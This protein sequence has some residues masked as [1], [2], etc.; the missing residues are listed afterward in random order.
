MRSMTLW[1][2]SAKRAEGLHRGSPKFHAPPEPVE[3]TAG[4]AGGRSAA[5][6]APRKLLPLRTLAKRYSTTEGWLHAEVAAGNL[7]A[8]CLEGEPRVAEADVGRWL[9]VHNW[10][11]DDRHADQ[12]SIPLSADAAASDE[13]PPA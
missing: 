9:Q 4:P 1:E 12:L 8:Y 10:E 11:S 2:K 13:A 5:P 7:R 3:E 6:Q